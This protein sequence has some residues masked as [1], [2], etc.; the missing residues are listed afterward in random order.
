MLKKFTINKLYGTTTVSIPFNQDG[1]NIFIGENGLGK[2]T[3]LNIL[4]FF[5]TKRF[6]KLTQYN[7]AYIEI[8]FS[9]NEK[10]SLKYSDL[11]SLHS[12]QDDRNVPNNIL[13]SILDEIPESI[14]QSLINDIQKKPMSREEL[15]NHPALQNLSISR[16]YPPRV[17]YDAILS[18][19]DEDLSEQ[20]KELKNSITKCLDGVNILY[21][22]TYRR[23]EE[24]LKNLNLTID[25]E[26][27][28]QR[29]TTEKLIQFGMN[30]VVHRF[31]L[32]QDSIQKLS[33][34]GLA[35]ISSEILSQLITGAP[36]IHDIHLESMNAEN[37]QII[38]A[39]V[40]PALSATDKARI[41]E[42]IESSKLKDEDRF[43]IYFVRK[44]I[45][46]Y[47]NQKHF[48]DRIKKYIQVCNRYFSFS[49]KELIYNESEVEFYLKS[50]FFPERKLLIKFLGKLSS[51]EKQI[52]SLFSKLYLASKDQKFIVLFDE[53]E[54]SLSIDWQ[55]LLLPDIIESGK[56]DT[57]I[58]VTHSPF[59]YDNNLKNSA[60]GLS[61]FINKD[62]EASE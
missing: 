49:K 62:F 28:Y 45:D 30:D 25:S 41:L 48:D 40:G 57:L 13:Q 3:V 37:I 53:P 31:K 23:I 19:V 5:L 42:K 20:L 1:V 33:S 27:R 36:Q 39:R 9:N 4:Y 26:E 51:G 24:D 16:R 55:E 47:E 12:I 58:T 34:Q 17:L 29:N 52:V 61:E 11:E 38:L 43:L 18:L 14:L 6:R 59:I 22:P 46:I 54:L 50:D 60:R 21:L 10:L 8:E 7:F 2:T 56:C 35:K 44:L 15:I 32:M